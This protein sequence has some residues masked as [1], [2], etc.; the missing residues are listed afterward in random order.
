V[1]T[2][3]TTQ[4]RVIAFHCTEG[5][6]MGTATVRY[7]QDERAAAQLIDSLGCAKHGCLAPRQRWNDG[8]DE[9]IAGINP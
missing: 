7:N 6:L 2:T 9:W 4:E 1:S 5:H 8:W 3:R